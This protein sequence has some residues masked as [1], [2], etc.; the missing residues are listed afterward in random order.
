MR[1]EDA[2]PAAV[3]AVNL[4]KGTA[5]SD[6]I[7]EEGSERMTSES[8]IPA[9]ARTEKRRLEVR[10]RVMQEPS[11]VPGKA[12]PTLSGRSNTA[13]DSPRVACRPRRS[14]RI[15]YSLQMR[16]S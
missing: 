9:S 14:L 5:M 6:Y 13:D 15:L 10:C 4:T 3:I 16:V 7:S 8:A 2:P 1:H 12:R 11:P